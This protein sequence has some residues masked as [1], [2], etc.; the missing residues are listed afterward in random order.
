MRVLKIR[1]YDV[2]HKKMCLMERLGGEFNGER[3][4]A[5]SDG[6]GFRH[7][8]VLDEKALHLMQFT[9][10]KDLNGV[11]IFE[12]DIVKYSNSLWTIEWKDF[13][14]HIVEVPEGSDR[15]RPLSYRPDVE[16]VGNRH[17]HP[18][19]LKDKGEAEG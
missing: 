12:G 1:V 11:E 14:Y 9:G 18:N 2:E 19:L 10:M 6:K 3:L 13:A 4:I 8:R 17:Q 7:E 15:E 16:V 5:Y